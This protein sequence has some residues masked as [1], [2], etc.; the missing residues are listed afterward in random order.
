MQQSQRNVQLPER[1]DLRNQIIHLKKKKVYSRHP[2]V[3][4]HALENSWPVLEK[5]KIK[6]NFQ[7]ART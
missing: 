1:A 3:E 6:L 5:L 4:A 7:K 2:R